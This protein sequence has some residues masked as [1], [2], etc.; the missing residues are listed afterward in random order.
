MSV[1]RLRSHEKTDPDTWEVSGGQIELFEK[2]TARDF[3]V[4]SV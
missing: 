3:D 2:N 1:F 4:L